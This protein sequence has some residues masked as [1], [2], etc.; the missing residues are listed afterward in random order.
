[1]LPAPSVRLSGDGLAETPSSGFAS[2]KITCPEKEPLRA[3]T[4]RMG[5]SFSSMPGR[6]LS[7]TARVMSAVQAIGPAGLAGAL[8]IVPAGA[9]A[10]SSSRLRPTVDQLRCQP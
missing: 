1:M 3:A 7:E 5:G 4:M 6:A 2:A 8:R 9:S 10:R